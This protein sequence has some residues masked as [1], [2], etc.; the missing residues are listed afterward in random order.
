MLRVNHL[1]VD[2]LMDVTTIPELWGVGV[3]NKKICLAQCWHTDY[4]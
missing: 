1:T 3:K 2:R 4:N